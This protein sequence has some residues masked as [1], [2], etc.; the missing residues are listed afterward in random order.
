[1]IKRTEPI[2]MQMTNPESKWPKSLVPESADRE[3]ALGGL[4]LFL[5]KGIRKGFYGRRGIDEDFIED[6]VQIALMR[7]VDNLGTFAGRSAFT[8][9]ALAIALRVGFSELRR[10]HW[11]NV[12]LEELREKGG[13]LVEEIATMPDP[14]DIMDRDSLVALMH[15]LIGTKLTQRQRDVVLAELSAVPQDE[16]ARQMNMTRNAVYKLS[17]DARKALRRALEDAGYNV[18][19]IRDTL[20]NERR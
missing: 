10:K 5:I 1:M 13:D 4:R 18:Q 19:Q 6:V 15:K 14:I 7:I 8:T 17:H 9:W 3:A 12:S 2:S 16:I 11:N 20:D